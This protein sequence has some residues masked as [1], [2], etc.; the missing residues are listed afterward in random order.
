[1]PDKT[2]TV[3]E[4]VARPVRTAVQMA[5]S[6]VATELI[7]IFLYDMDERGYMAVFAALTLLF[8]WIQTAVENYNGKGFLR[9]VPPVTS[10]VVDNDPNGGAA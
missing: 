7:D 1:M 9:N 8:G 5:P 3:S 4:A 10:P 2:T 6:A